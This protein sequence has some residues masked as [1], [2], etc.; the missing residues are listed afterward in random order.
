MKH[1][2]VSEK[3][4]LMGDDVADVLLEYAK[5]LADAG[6]ADRVTV[7]VIGP[8]GNEVDIDLLLDSGT[9]I[10]AESTNSTA[11]TPDNRDNIADLRQRLARATPWH[12]TSDAVDTGEYHWTDE[13]GSPQREDRADMRNTGISSPDATR[14][15]GG[16]REAIGSLESLD[17]A[18]SGSPL[19]V[20]YS[21]GPE[22]D[23]DGSSVDTESGLML[24]GLSVNP[25]DPEPWWVRPRLDWLA[26]QLCQYKQ[27]RD[28]NPERV[29]WVVRGTEV[30]RGPDCE[31]L[32]VDVEFVAELSDELLTEAEQRYHQ[33][34]HAGK[35]PEA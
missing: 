12:A 22:A 28:R 13:Y 1:V 17:A 30:G 35:G 4:L 23:S 5:V 27:L 31:P 29:A 14:R 25:L 10:V 11:N 32:L 15:G 26:R 24:P 21:L 20:R 9:T 2:T 34:F 18:M 3:S 6:R 8:D 7:R 33:R 19:Y 16:T